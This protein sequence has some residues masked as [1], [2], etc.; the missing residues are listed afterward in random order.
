MPLNIAAAQPSD[1]ERYNMAIRLTMRKFIKTVNNENDLDDQRKELLIYGVYVGLLTD[2]LDVDGTGVVINI[3]ATDPDVAPD[4][5]VDTYFG[6]VLNREKIERA[7]SKPLPLK[8]H[9]G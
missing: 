9:F 2:L 6:T 7:L 4:N 8:R 3:E 1:D 5:N